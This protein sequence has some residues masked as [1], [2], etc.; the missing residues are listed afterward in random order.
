MGKGT[1]WSVIEIDKRSEEYIASG[2]NTMERQ[3]RFA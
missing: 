3:I 1:V 2:P